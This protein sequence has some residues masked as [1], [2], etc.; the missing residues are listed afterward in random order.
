[1]NNFDN[2]T[3]KIGDAMQD[4]NKETY[5][6]LGYY[7][8]SSRSTS[9]GCPYCGHLYLN[10]GQLTSDEINSSHFWELSAPVRVSQTIQ[11]KKLK[12]NGS[13][14][15]KYRPF[16]NKVG[17][18]NMESI[19]SKLWIVWGLYRIGDSNMEIKTPEDCKTI[20][21]AARKKQYAD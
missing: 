17:S 2:S 10:I 5:V 4:F 3:I 7:L 6:Y 9:N 8:D 16:I 12:Q 20:I 21:E 13:Y 11:D 14:R 1:M 19:H 15:K 18:V